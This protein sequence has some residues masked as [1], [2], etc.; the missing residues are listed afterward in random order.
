MNLKRISI[1]NEIFM[2]RDLSIISSISHV[3]TKC[4]SGLKLNPDSCKLPLKSSWFCMK[5]IILSCFSAVT[6]RS[7]KV[8]TSKNPFC[9]S[10]IL[11]NYQ[12]TIHYLIFTFFV[13][14]SVISKL[15]R[16]LKILC[17]TKTFPGPNAPIG[18]SPWTS[19][20]TLKM[21]NQC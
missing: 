3:N 16:K 4:R 11:K 17:K 12:T 13:P 18:I 1:R 21:L 6:P 10:T 9:C 7:F 2:H 20:T 19:A 14:K 8:E 5:I 15:S